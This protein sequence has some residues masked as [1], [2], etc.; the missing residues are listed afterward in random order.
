MDVSGC[1]K[2]Q[3]TVIETLPGPLFVAAGAGSGKTF[4]LKLRTAN[5]FLPNASGFQLDSIQQVLAI[6]FT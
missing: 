2:A 4:T 3:R 6:T 1:S 5:A